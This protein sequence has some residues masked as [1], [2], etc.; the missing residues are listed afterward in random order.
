M[1]WHWLW[2]Y[3]NEF[4]YSCDFHQVS[5]SIW[6]QVQFTVLATAWYTEV[7]WVRCLTNI[8]HQRQ[9]ITGSLR[10]S[11]LILKVTKWSNLFQGQH[12]S[13]KCIPGRQKSQSLPLHSRIRSSIGWLPSLF[14]YNW[15]QF[16]NIFTGMHEGSMVGY[17]Q[18]QVHIT[19]FSWFVNLSF[20]PKVSYTVFFYW[21]ALKND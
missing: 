3:D 4:H 12:V 1:H 17:L 14:W 21:S 13:T 8:I 19:S 6:Y 18:C 16:V 5:K 11:Y 9:V 2:Y 15:Y 7:F 20:I 10:Y